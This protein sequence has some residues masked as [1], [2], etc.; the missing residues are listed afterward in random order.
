M[1]P[2]FTLLLAMLGLAALAWVWARRAW[3]PRAALYAGLGIL[4]S[5]GPFLFTRFIIPEAI[6]S[7]LLLSA[8]YAFFL[9]LEDQRTVYIYWTYAALALATLT[10]GLI[11][12]VFFAGTALPYL[13]ITGHWRRWR[14]LNLASGLLLYLAIAAPWFILATLEIGRASCRERV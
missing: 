10:K 12:P 14:S 1:R 3:G 6:L 2:L 11:G 4:T 13:V 9:S 7:L 5:I 8:L